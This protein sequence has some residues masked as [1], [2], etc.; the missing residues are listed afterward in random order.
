M[1]LPDLPPRALKLESSI[2]ILIN[3]IKFRIIEYY[4]KNIQISATC[5]CRGGHADSNKIAELSS[6]KTSGGD[7][8][9]IFLKKLKHFVFRCQNWKNYRNK[10]LHNCIFITIPNFRTLESIIYNFSNFLNRKFILA[11][12][13]SNFN[14]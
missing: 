10:K 9:G 3:K 2:F 8:S 6:F 1:K 7:R 4:E 11:F 14:L 12:R 13:N 5:V